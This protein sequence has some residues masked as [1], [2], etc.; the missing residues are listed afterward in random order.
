MF[1]CHVNT[2]KNIYSLEKRR[3]I[4][5]YLN[6]Y[7]NDT[8]KARKFELSFSQS[9]FRAFCRYVNCWYTCSIRGSR[10]SPVPCRQCR[11]GLW[12]HAWPQLPSIGS[13]PG[14]TCSPSSWS[15]PWQRHHRENNHFID[16][17]RY[18]KF[19]F[20][21]EN[22]VHRLKILRCEISNYP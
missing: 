5:K 17:Q 8:M 16:S 7:G 14:S 3:T 22:Y 12:C 2:L 21:W 15:P 19:L 20:K 11:Q 13:A 9:K 1:K 4:A 18:P 6:C 10:S